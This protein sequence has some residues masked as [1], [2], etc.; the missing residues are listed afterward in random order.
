MDQG[1]AALPVLDRT[2]LDE[3]TGGDKELLEELTTLYLDDVEGQFAELANAVQAGEFE[4]IAAIA[5]GLKG[6]SASMG[7]TQIAHFFKVL[8]EGGRSGQDAGLADALHGAREA[9]ARVGSLLRGE[10]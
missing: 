9:F 2:M 8:E 6:A 10:A 4:R 7:A 3:V 5:H 1:A